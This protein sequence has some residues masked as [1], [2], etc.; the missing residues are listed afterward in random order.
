M[1]VTILVWLCIATYAIVV[2]GWWAR[3]VLISLTRSF[4]LFVDPVQSKDA[5]PRISV[6]I[7]ARNESGHIAK[8]VSSLLEQGSVVRDVIV[9]DD[10]SNDGTADVALSAAR[11]DPRVRVNTVA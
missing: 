2:A 7:P 11:G 9:V 6:V 3:H 10:R 1:A 5:N 4:D 8:C